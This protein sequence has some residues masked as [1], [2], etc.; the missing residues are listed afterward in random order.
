MTCSQDEYR[1]DSENLWGKKPI[2]LNCAIQNVCV[3]SSVQ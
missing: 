3:G 1:E 2:F